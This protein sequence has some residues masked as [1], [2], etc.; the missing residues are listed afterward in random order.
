MLEGR[1][2]LLSDA[3]GDVPAGSVGGLV[4]D[5]TRFLNRWEVSLEGRSLSL[6]KSRAVDYYSAAFYLTNPELEGLHP[7][8]IAVRRFRFVATACSSSLPP[9]TPAW[10]R[11]GSSCG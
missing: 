6:L 11:R 8:T 9:S 4:H 7:N 1:T 5:D 3:L 2:F 10:R